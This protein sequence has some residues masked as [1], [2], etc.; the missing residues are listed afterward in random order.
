MDM[1]RVKAVALMSC[2]VGGAVAEVEVLQLV[3]KVKVKVEKCRRM[4]ERLSRGRE[5]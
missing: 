4:K 3:V 2:G 5:K 1:V